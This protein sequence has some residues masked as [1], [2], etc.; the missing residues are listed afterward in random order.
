MVILWYFV[1]PIVKLSRD[2]ID[3]LTHKNVLVEDPS[4]MEFGPL[5]CFCWDV[6]LYDSV[7][8]KDHSLDPPMVSGLFEPVW[9]DAGV[10]VLVLKMTPGLWGGNRILRVL[11]FC[12]RILWGIER[13]FMKVFQGVVC[14]SVPQTRFKGLDL[15]S[16][17]TDYDFCRNF[18]YLKTT[19][20]LQVV[21]GD[22]A[23]MGSLRCELAYPISS[24]EYHVWVDG[25]SSKNPTNGIW[26]RS[27]GQFTELQFQWF[28]AAVLG[29]F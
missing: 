2:Q 11:W 20:M 17:L 3:N 22:K 16:L 25:V 29:A 6:C 28:N 12:M 18:P 1:Y 10:V 4:E 14:L 13:I 26:N 7:C 15:W 27:Q 21:F 23:D 19:H 9:Y 24:Q 8:P 5:S